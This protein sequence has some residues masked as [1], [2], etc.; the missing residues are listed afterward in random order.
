MKIY[1]PDNNSFVETDTTQPLRLF[2]SFRSKPFV[3]FTRY[4]DT[5]ALFTNLWYFAWSVLSAK[6]IFPNCTFNLHTDNKGVEYLSNLPYDVITT[7]LEG[8]KHSNY[9]WASGKFRALENEEL[10]A[11]H[12]DG[13]VILSSTLAQELLM[14]EQNEVLVQNY[15]GIYAREIK[16]ITPLLKNASNVFNKGS[17]CCGVIGINN[18]VLK[19]SY[20]ETYNHYAHLINKYE[21]ILSKT[22]NSNARITFDLLFE[23]SSLYNLCLEGNYKVKT[24]CRSLYELPNLKHSGYEH[25]MGKTKYEN[26]NINRAKE[27]VRSLNLDFYNFLTDKEKT[28]F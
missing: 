25:F 18:Q 6:S 8:L 19:Q 27:A 15:E 10:G 2:H 23:Q 4:S 16:Y 13:D 1:S 28:N 3:E 14:Y 7:D 21:H 17:L 20:I 11:I 5:Q 9:L 26:D 24:L 22:M 12:I